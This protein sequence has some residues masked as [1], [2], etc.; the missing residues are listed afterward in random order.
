MSETLW[1]I[2]ADL[3]QKLSLRIRVVISLDQSLLLFLLSDSEIGADAVK[4]FWKVVF[5]MKAMD[6]GIEAKYVTLLVAT[7]TEI[8]ASLIIEIEGWL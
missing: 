4:D 6:P 5:I 3:E 8:E 2:P 1:L 7:M